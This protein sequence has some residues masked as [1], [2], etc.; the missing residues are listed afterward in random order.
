MPIPNLQIPEDTLGQYLYMAVYD[1]NEIG[2][3]WLPKVNRGFPS[4]S[5]EKYYRKCYKHDKNPIAS[6]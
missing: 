6:Q 2:Y 3:I 1:Q 5:R 4:T